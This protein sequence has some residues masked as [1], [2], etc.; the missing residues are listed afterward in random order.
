MLGGAIIAENVGN[1][2]WSHHMSILGLACVVRLLILPILFLIVAKYLPMTPGLDQVLMLQ[3][4]M[5]VATF[6]IIM[7]RLFGGDIDT[8]LRIVLG[9]SAIGLVTIPLWISLGCWFLGIVLD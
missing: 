2:K 9:T 4:S 7:T 8:S 1:V 5:P 6:P 3:A